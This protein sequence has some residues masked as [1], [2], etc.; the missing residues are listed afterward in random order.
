MVRYYWKEKFTIYSGDPQRVSTTECG[1]V[2]RAKPK[3]AILSTAF[4]GSFDDKS[5][6]CGFRSR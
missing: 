1:L 6:F 5:R 2:N 3:S 4:F